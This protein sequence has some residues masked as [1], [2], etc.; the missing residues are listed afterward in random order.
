[1][2]EMI[3]IYTDTQK[4]MV[5][6]TAPFFAPDARDRIKLIIERIGPIFQ[7]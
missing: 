2:E 5:I 7:D 6:S 3:D 4:Q 1:M